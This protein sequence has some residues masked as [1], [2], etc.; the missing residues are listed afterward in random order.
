ML[1]TGCR[2]RANTAPFSL[3]YLKSSYQ[4]V[5]RYQRALEKAYRN[6][7]LD[8]SSVRTDKSCIP[9]MAQTDAPVMPKSTSFCRLLSLFD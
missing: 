1:W 2:K 4:R 5:Y 7:R 9:V 6:I 3:E 8:Y